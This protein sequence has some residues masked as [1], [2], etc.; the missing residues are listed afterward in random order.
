MQDIL[1][2][3]DIID[4]VEHD[5]P[6]RLYWKRRRL[7]PMVYIESEHLFKKAYRFTKENVRKLSA[8]LAPFLKLSAGNRG[9]PFLAE[10]IMCS[11]LQILG[12]GHFFRTEGACSGT[13]VST[14]HKNLYR[15]VI[16]A[17]PI[18]ISKCFGS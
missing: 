9:D 18:L 5:E 12:G 11:G 1:D 2:I 17:S 16:F 10:Q 13:G 8:E 3:L 7:N 14:A 15:C 6:E 4:V